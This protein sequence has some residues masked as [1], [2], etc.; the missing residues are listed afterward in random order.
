M[1][2]NPYE[3]S[4]VHT[5]PIVDERV[6]LVVFQRSMMWLFLVRLGMDLGWG[7]A[8]ELLGPVLVWIFWLAYFVIS[9]FVAYFV[10]RLVKVIYGSG[11]AV[12]CAIITFA[13]CIGIFAILIL[14][15][16]VVDRLRKLGVKVGFMGAT[17][18]QFRELNQA[19]ESRS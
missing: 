19:Q 3:S 12:I 16:N 4:Q 8:L 17:A 2:L 11:P 9:L 7:V 6:E 13:P 5:P 18:A 1:E 10:F 14:N 15:G